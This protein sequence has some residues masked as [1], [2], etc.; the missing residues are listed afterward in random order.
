M[1][2][3][4]QKR[5]SRERLVYVLAV[6]L[7]IIRVDIWWWG[8]EMPLVLFGWINVPMLYQFGIWVAGSPW[9]SIP[10]N[11]FGWTNNRG[12]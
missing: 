4:V 6:I 10:L 1:S 11:T 2:I 8:E 12:R 5:R 7:M 9:Y 3:D